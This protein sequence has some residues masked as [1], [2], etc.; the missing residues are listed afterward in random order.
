MQEDFEKAPLPEKVDPLNPQ[1]SEQPTKKY[2]PNPNDLQ[3]A[4][5]SDHRMTY[6]I[7]EPQEE[8]DMKDSIP[9]GLDLLGLKDACTKRDFDS[10]PRKQI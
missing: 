1:H 8:E 2:T 3:G 10:I 7:P 6:Q 4:T 9:Y 5:L